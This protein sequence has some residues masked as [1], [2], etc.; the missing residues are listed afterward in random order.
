MSQAAA[1][2][3]IFDLQKKEVSF[4]D[5]ERILEKLREQGFRITRQ[6]RILLDIILDEQNLCCKEIYYR[7]SKMDKNIGLSTVY[8]MLS[9]LEDI[10][11]V[12]RRSMYR[13]DERRDGRE[14]DICCIELDNGT[15]L[16]FS[17]EQ[18]RQVVINGLKAC[19]HIADQ[20]IKN[21]RLGQE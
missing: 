20:N 8:R 11:A 10:G 15:V 12:T 4:L 2:A 5:K 1:L 13:V 6:R 18:W 9:V 14:K 21:I 17:Q 7:A 16:E 3:R 19:G